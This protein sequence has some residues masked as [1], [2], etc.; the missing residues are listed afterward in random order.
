MTKCL[1][2]E[3]KFY[4]YITHFFCQKIEWILN[5]VGKIMTKN[6]THSTEQKTFDGIFK[7]ELYVNTMYVKMFI[8]GNK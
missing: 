7:N 3:N 5:A 6:V 8:R 2:H 1:K 4:R